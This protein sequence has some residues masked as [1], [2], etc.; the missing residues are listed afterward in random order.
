[1]ARYVAAMLTDLANDLVSAAVAR[2][3][4]SGVLIGLKK[5]DGGTR[6]ITLGEC[7]LKTASRI[8]IEA[9]T[10]ALRRTFRYPVRGKRREAQKRSSTR[11]ELSSVRQAHRELRR[12]S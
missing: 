12:H 11:R 8:A 1:M 6:P 5:P 3:L 2:R 4:N 9:S 10:D 7:F